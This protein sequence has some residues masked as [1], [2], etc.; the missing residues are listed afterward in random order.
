[1]PALIAANFFPRTT[2]PIG[3][4]SETLFSIK[5]V[6]SQNNLSHPE[7]FHRDIMKCISD[8]DAQWLQDEFERLNG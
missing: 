6:C 7:H 5:L 4:N 1:V 8:A 2:L 3:S